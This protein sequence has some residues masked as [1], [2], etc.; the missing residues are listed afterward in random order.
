MEHPTA[1]SGFEALLDCPKLSKVKHIAWDVDVTLVPISLNYGAAVREQL[2]DAGVIEQLVDAARARDIENVVVS[3]NPQFSAIATKVP[4]SH[5]QR[6]DEFLEL[7]FDRVLLGYYD[8]LNQSKVAELPGDATLLI[9]DSKGECRV[10]QARGARATVTVH[11]AV[12][13]AFKTGNF[14]K[15]ARP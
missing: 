8:R 13:V 7:G 4:G 9:D 12:H 14:T 5:L 1:V 2:P 11:D 6:T 3:R 10:A 15:W